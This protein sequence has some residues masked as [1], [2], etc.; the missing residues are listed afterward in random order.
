MI[1]S[2]HVVFSLYSEFKSSQHFRNL[3][4]ADP[5]VMGGPGGASQSGKEGPQI[6]QIG[7]AGAAEVLAVGGA[8]PT[9]AQLR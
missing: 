6:A 2:L 1:E 9:I 3:E 7:D 5:P 8:S 4:S